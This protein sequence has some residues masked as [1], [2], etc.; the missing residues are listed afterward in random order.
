MDTFREV[1]EWTFEGPVGEATDLPT[2]FLL[3]AVL[4][5]AHSAGAGIASA[6]SDA[7]ASLLGPGTRK[8][9]LFRRRLAFPGPPAMVA[10]MTDDLVKLE[11]QQR[12][13]PNKFRALLRALEALPGARDLRLRAERQRFAEPGSRGGAPLDG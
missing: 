2:A 3:G 6:L 11:F 4:V 8:W 12:L 7:L 9:A 10:T 1:V 13:K 5:F